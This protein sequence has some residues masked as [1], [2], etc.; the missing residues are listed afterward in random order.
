LR[1]ETLLL[2]SSTRRRVRVNIAEGERCINVIE[3]KQGLEASGRYD[4]YAR[5][6]IYWLPSEVAPCQGWP[7]T[8]QRPSHFCVAMSYFK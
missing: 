4:C 8:T 1:D 2:V 5:T 7:D 3:L 6:G